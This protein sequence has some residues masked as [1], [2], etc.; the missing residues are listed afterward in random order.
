MKRTSL[1]HH[2]SLNRLEPHSDNTKRIEILLKTIGSL[3][4]VHRTGN[5]RHCRTVDGLR[6]ANPDTMQRPAGLSARGNTLSS[7][8]TLRPI[9]AQ[10]VPHFNY[11]LLRTIAPSAKRAVQI[12]M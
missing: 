8:K 4:V 11:G 2:Q 5:M 3:L 7:G 10:A 9:A 12:D 1:H 6:A